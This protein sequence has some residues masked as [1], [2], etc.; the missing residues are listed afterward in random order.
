MD[1]PPQ[2]SACRD[3]HGT[4]LKPLAVGGENAPDPATLQFYPGDRALSESDARMAF[5]Q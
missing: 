2:K 3:H 4:R 1:A 5:E